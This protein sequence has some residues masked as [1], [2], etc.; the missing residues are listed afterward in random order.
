MP[1]TLK[2]NKPNEKIECLNEFLKKN[3]NINNVLF[4]QIF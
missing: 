4:Y 3:K 1:L 2:E